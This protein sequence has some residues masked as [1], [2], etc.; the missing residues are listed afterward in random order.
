MLL[1]VHVISYRVLGA[2]A[3]SV[4][5]DPPGDVLVFVGPATVRRTRQLG[6]PG[7]RNRHRIHEAQRVVVHDDGVSPGRDMSPLPREPGSAPV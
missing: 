5:P 1:V 2:Q 6:V 7:S 3:D 4:I